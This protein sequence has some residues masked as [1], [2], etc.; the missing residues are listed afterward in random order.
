MTARLWT[1]GWVAFTLLVVIG[2][3]D[4]YVAA[5]NDAVGDT[6]SNV[7]QILADWWPPL[8]M[9][10]AVGIAHMSTQA[11][12]IL[13]PVGRWFLL[14]WTTLAVTMLSHAGYIT[15]GRWSVIGL[16]ALGGVLGAT[17]LSQSTAYS[18]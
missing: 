17:L 10:G 7:W 4:V 9:W 6:I 5:F 16:V 18:L 15:N 14:V 1:L 8:A 3:Y 2:A 11:D 13:D 12:P